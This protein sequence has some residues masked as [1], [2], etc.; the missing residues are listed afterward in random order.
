LAPE[1]F[2]HL[3]PFFMPKST[4]RRTGVSDDPN[5]YVF[6]RDGVDVGRC[7]LRTLSNNE[8]RW[9]WTIFIGNHV[10]SV[11]TGVPTAGYTATL[12]EAKEQL[13]RSFDQMVAAGVVQLEEARKGSGQ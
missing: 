4:R 1:L 12:E 3:E 13:R 10:K 6:R 11:V 8:Q 5:A 2:H 7:Y 9:S